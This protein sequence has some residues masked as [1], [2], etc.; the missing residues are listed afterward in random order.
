MSL[1]M[2]VPVAP[3]APLEYASGKFGLLLLL[4][5]TRLRTKWLVQICRKQELLQER[6]HHMWHMEMQ[7]G[8]AHRKA[9]PSTQS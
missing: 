9:E 4:V 6:H 5:E 2:A 8:L 7:Q 3:E 1:R